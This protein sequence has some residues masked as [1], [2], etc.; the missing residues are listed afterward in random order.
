MF[1]TRLYMSLKNFKHCC[2]LK[3]HV[4][5]WTQTVT[6]LPQDYTNGNEKE[7]CDL[8]RGQYLNYIE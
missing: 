2:P 6:T 7:K 3:Q 5:Y 4:H 8:C 1:N